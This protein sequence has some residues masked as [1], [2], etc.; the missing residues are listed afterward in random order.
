[1]SKTKNNQRKI[2]NNLIKEVFDLKKQLVLE[3][4]RIGSASGALSG[5]KERVPGET[6][7][8]RTR[9]PACAPLTNQQ[10]IEIGRKR[11]TIAKG[12]I[13]SLNRKDIKRARKFLD[14]AQEYG[15]S[16]EMLA[17][18]FLQDHTDNL[19]DFKRRM[20][21]RSIVSQ[22]TQYLKIK[23]ERA[24]EANVGGAILR[25]LAR[26]FKG[27]RGVTSRAVTSN[28]G[29]ILAV[30]A[31]ASPDSFM[32]FLELSVNLLS[33]VRE[34]FL[35]DTWNSG[36]MASAIKY[37]DIP[38]N[39]KNEKKIKQFFSL[40][41]NEN[42]KKITTPSSSKENKRTPGYGP[43]ALTN[44]TAWNLPND[45]DRWFLESNPDT[46]SS[47]RYKKIKK[48]QITQVN[49]EL[50]KRKKEIG[51]IDYSYRPFLPRVIVD[52]EADDYFNA[53]I[54]FKRLAEDIPD[55][56]DDRGESSSGAPGGYL[57]VDDR[58]A[59]ELAI[60]AA[61]QK[62]NPYLYLCFCLQFVYFH[63]VP[64]GASASYMKRA[65]NNMGI[66]SYDTM[67]TD[68]LRT[69]GKKLYSY[70]DL[71]S[72]IPIQEDRYNDPM[73]AGMPPPSDSGPY[74]PAPD[75]RPYVR[76][77]QDTLPMG[78]E[79]DPCKDMSDEERARAQRQGI[80][81]TKLVVA[82]DGELY[83]KGFKPLNSGD[84]NVMAS[85]LGQNFDY[86][87]FLEICRDKIMKESFKDSSFEADFTMW[88]VKSKV[89]PLNEKMDWPEFLK[90]FCEFGD[91][92][93]DSE[94]GQCKD[95]PEASNLNA[96]SRFVKKE[97][98]AQSENEFTLWPSLL[99]WYY[100]TLPEAYTLPAI[101]KLIG[102]GAAGVTT[103]VAGASRGAQVVNVASKLKGPAMF[104]GV[105][106][107]LWF[108]FTDPL[109]KKDRGKIIDA[110]ERTINKLRSEAGKAI[111]Q[112][113]GNTTSWE[114]S[115]KA[116]A[117]IYDSWVNSLQELLDEI[118][119]HVRQRFKTGGASDCDTMKARVSVIAKI[120]D[121]MAGVASSIRSLSFSG[122]SQFV[123]NSENY[124]EVMNAFCTGHEKALEMFDTLKTPDT[125]LT[126]GLNESVDTKISLMKKSKGNNTQKIFNSY[127]N[128]NKL[129]RENKAGDRTIKNIIDTLFDEKDTTGLYGTSSPAEL[130]VL[131]KNMIQDMKTF[132]L[133]SKNNN[134][135]Q[136]KVL[137][138]MTDGVRNK[139]SMMSDLQITSGL[140]SSRGSLYSG[141]AKFEVS[142][143]LK[144]I[145]EM[146][147]ERYI[148]K[149]R[150][151]HYSSLYTSFRKGRSVKPHLDF[152]KHAL[153]FNVN[154]SPSEAW[155]FANYSGNY[156]IIGL[157]RPVGL[158]YAF[159]AS[160]SAGT[161]VRDVEDLGSVLKS[162]TG[163]D[164]MPSTAG[165]SK[166]YEEDV[167]LSGDAVDHF[168]PTW[169][170]TGVKPNSSIHSAGIIPPNSSS[171]GATLG[172]L[173][174]K[175][176]TIY[177]GSAGAQG[178]NLL[179]SATNTE[180]LTISLLIAMEQNQS[181]WS[182]AG[183]NE[184]D[185][186]LL[187]EFTKFY[188]E[189]A[190]IRSA[191]YAVIEWV[192]HYETKLAARTNIENAAAAEIQTKVNQELKSMIGKITGVV[193]RYGASSKYKKDNVEIG[194]FFLPN[195]SQNLC[196]IEESFS[197]GSE[198][199]FPYY[200][201]L[202][203]LSLFDG[204]VTTPDK[205]KALKECLRIFNSGMKKIKSIAPAV[206]QAGAIKTKEIM[207]KFLAS[208]RAAIKIDKHL[209]DT[210]Q[211]KAQ[212]QGGLGII[213]K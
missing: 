33:V 64:I 53:Y 150:A 79:H 180:S 185:R 128:D 123:I 87:Q 138:A 152:M 145:M 139:K 93:F 108:F 25:L 165:G 206:D 98:E 172:G 178:N 82:P 163:V 101:V 144:Q 177:R 13:K 198:P 56:F 149:I 188:L 54:S 8:G 99:A 71:R 212:S 127:F 137:R 72:T 37:V 189:F 182:R 140:D 187:W 44:F 126:P 213:Q 119:D 45:I 112:L 190:R 19:D 117:E 204:K 23:P 69:W 51:D 35:T 84:K 16:E 104:L 83:T 164:Y 17:D 34:S 68:V 75:S 41:E 166:I 103:A 171:P 80:D 38:D 116:T 194:R 201:S 107:M 157:V 58:V 129:L 142:E 90:C 10:K 203:R 20:L 4:Q 40:F 9:M 88:L 173:L 147:G 176:N 27:S 121:L 170:K 63:L 43:G 96:D 70:T 202:N 210:I 52:V 118:E 125:M 195:E 76:V 24:L 2:L 48:K 5:P 65:S 85:L 179:N 50:E 32:Q 39:P 3:D 159:V 55:S 192:I 74:D 114:I 168:G 124:Y 60:K 153:Y 156:N 181:A 141:N 28:A 6:D 91:G 160:N 73:D 167:S 134:T 135:V 57:W 184:K 205:R 36:K 29:K 62:A 191:F 154:I 92:V 211:G 18:A 113:S 61:E 22:P 197:I 7:V 97:I 31:V 105:G 66:K 133:Y 14:K 59:K 89:D 102:A 12:F 109:N 11:S 169:H 26:L 122:D 115:P 146:Q 100:V 131:K 47:A 77:S 120:N 151:H 158:D 174:N 196:T 130:A 193:R 186:L 132:G 161:M 208:I 95:S 183:K 1:M 162:I 30:T 155:Q 81:C 200:D 15:I 86:K 21:A 148:S 199:K 136:L 110:Y 111:K 175:I 46:F 49:K 209:Y 207:F 67:F 94:T 143:Q 106:I 78:V 42:L